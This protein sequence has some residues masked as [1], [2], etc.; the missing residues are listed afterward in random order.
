MID[1][2]LAERDPRRRLEKIREQ[3]SRLKE[4]KQALGAE[5]LTRVVGWTPSTL[6]SL[7][8]RMVTARSP[9]TWS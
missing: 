6:L 2:P 1:L 4:S 9:S 3:T 8:G 5:V 7:G